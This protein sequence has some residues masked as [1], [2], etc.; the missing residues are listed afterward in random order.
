ML[1]LDCVRTAIRSTGRIADCAI[2]WKE[3]ALLAVV[4]LKG[5]LSAVNAVRVV[6]QIQAG[7]RVMSD[8][9]GD[10]HVAD[11]YPILMYRGHY[12]YKAL[13]GMLIEF[14]G[15]KRRLIPLTC[16]SRLSSVSGL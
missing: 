11:F 4:E 5:G 7:V 13:Q 3:K 16:G 14:R 12:P 9:A 2:L 1:N 15:R 10:Q 6:Q 8:L